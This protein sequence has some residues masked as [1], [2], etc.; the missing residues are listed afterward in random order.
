MLER[1][2]GMQPL[3]HDEPGCL[4]A[5][6]MIGREYQPRSIRAVLNGLKA[7]GFSGIGECYIQPGLRADEFQLGLGFRFTDQQPPS[8][9]WGAC[10]DR[11]PQGWWAEFIASI[12]RALGE[13]EHATLKQDECVSSPVL[14]LRIGMR[15]ISAAGFENGSPT[16]ISEPTDTDRGSLFIYACRSLSP[17]SPP[18]SS[19]P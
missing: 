1:E 13:D 6:A 5:F 7:M 9:W 12:A 11:P 2:R 10:F 3:E 15:F 16:W 17:S 8:G 18:G 19:S 4:L 14:G